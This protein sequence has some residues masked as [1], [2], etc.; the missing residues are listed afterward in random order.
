[1]RPTGF[2]CVSLLVFLGLPLAQCKLVHPSD[3][4]RKVLASAKD[5]D[6]FELADGVYTT[7]G[8]SPERGGKIVPGDWMFQINKGVTVVAQHA[9]QAVL[10]GQNKY[11]VFNIDTI[12]N[13]AT[14]G[15]LTVLDGLN[16]TRGRAIYPGFGA[17][18]YCF[19][20]NL[21][22][23]RCN[24]YDNHAW[25]GNNTF[26]S[27]EGGG[28]SI[29]SEHVTISDTNIFGNDA[30]SGGAI[31]LGGAKFAG[32]LDI[33]NCNIYSNRA[34]V[35]SGVSINSGTV[36][37]SGTNIYNNSIFGDG[38]F[39]GGGVWIDRMYGGTV[40]A[41]DTT[42]IYANKPDDCWGS[43]PWTPA[44]ACGRHPADL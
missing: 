14:T 31:K 22:V 27:G 32:S 21:S 37:I 8:I 20:G 12:T 1:M 38:N 39:T 41:D 5:G 33:V 15:G 25:T 4:L 42:F 7:D 13:A 30:S 16:I 18:I 43:P 40:T 2:A 9:G 6:I 23:R 17:G 19:S 44:A 3:N 29:D 24:I 28:I 34:P 36:N 10:D 11:R 26:S 35:G